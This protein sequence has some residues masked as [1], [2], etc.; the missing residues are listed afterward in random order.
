M[1]KSNLLRI[2]EI[3]ETSKN[4]EQCIES[5]NLDTYSSFICFY[6]LLEE[7]IFSYEKEENY[8][9]LIK[10]SFYLQILYQ[11]LSPSKKK[12]YRQKF[13]KIILGLLILIIK[14]IIKKFFFV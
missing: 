11:K 14:N 13:I 7:A 1:N 4:I 5:L 9:F 8:E 2:K 12:F 3:I 6:C 10:T